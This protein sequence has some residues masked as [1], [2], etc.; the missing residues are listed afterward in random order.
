[1]KTLPTALIATAT[2][3]LLALVPAVNAESTFFCEDDAANG[4]ARET[5]GNM[6]YQNYYWPG[7]AVLHA[8]NWLFIHTFNFVNA[9]TSCPLVLP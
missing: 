9:A 8:E 4:Y 1:M 7:D 5:Y 3:A 2:L 6:V